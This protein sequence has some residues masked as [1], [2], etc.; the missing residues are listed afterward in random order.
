M[1][2]EYKL[3][4]EEIVTCKKCPLHLSRTNAVPGWGKSRNGIA[5]VGEAPG[6]EEDAKG[7]PFVG[8][9]G[10]LL[11]ELLRKVGLLRED[12]YITNVVKC[13]PP[14]NRRPRR[15][16]AFA[17]LE[18]L[19]REMLLVEPK[20][21]VLLGSTPSEYLYNEVLPYRDIPKVKKLNEIRGKLGKTVIRGRVFISLPTYHPAAVLRNPK[22]KEALEK[23]LK[24]ALDF[25]S[26]NS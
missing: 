5:L 24:T 21:I 14:G 15:V 8:R 17:C 19:E 11:D 6:R 2:N 13:R 3:L 22:L 1:E 16:E 23:D 12:V 4:R 9:G 26:F 18:Y 10:K 20:I 7:I 25:I